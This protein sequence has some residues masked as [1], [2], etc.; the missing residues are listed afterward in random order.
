[1]HKKSIFGI[2]LLLFSITLASCANSN[3]IKVNNDKIEYKKFDNNINEDVVELTT[4]TKEITMLDIAR[5]LEK[6]KEHYPLSDE[7]IEKYQQKDGGYIDNALKAGLVVDKEIHEP[8]QKWHFFESWYYPSIKDGTLTE[9][10]SAK[11]RVY[12][13]LKCPELLLWIYEACE[14]DPVKVK[15]AKEVAEEAKA[16]GTH[17]A[18]MAKNMRACVPWEDIETTILNK[19]DI[20]YESYNVSVNEG[21]GFNVAGLK[22]SY[23]VGSEVS[24]T[25]NVIDSTKEIDVVKYNDITLKATS[26]AKYKFT[27]PNEDVVIDITLKEKSGNPIVEF[28]GASYNIKY[29]LGTRKTAKLLDTTD[30]LFNTFELSNGDNIINGISQMEYIYGGAYGRKDETQWVIGDIIKFGTTKVNGSFT[31]DLSVSVNCI[32]ITGYVSDASCKI[33]VGDSDNFDNA[34]TYTCSNMNV[35]TKEVVEANQT[36]TITIEFD[37]TD[38]LKIATTNKKP[39]YITSIEF[40]NV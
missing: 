18:T 4:E 7:F 19:E 34:T 11:S 35:T 28:N 20:T 37:N 1:M 2:F 13:N 25:V 16:N 39:F 24:F 22:S 29:D 17:I 9:T 15:N 10:E 6:K 5:F 31:F 12:S 33:Q 21:E 26:G 8:N 3:L 36:S 14:V 40:L 38:S 27:M 32:K 30:D 23:D